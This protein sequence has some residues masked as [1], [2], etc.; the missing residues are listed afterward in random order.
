MTLIEWAKATHQNEPMKA[1]AVTAGILVIGFIVGSVIDHLLLAIASN[2]FASPIFAWITRILGIFIVFQVGKRISQLGWY[3]LPSYSDPA[4]IQQQDSGRQNM[5]TKSVSSEASNGVVYYQPV[6]TSPQGTMLVARQPGETVF[7]VKSA[8]RFWFWFL[9]LAFAVCAFTL[10]PALGGYIGYLTWDGLPNSFA[11]NPTGYIAGG[12]FWGFVAFVGLTVFAHF[13]TRPWVQV[14]V[15]PDAVNYGGQKY[16]RKHH[17]GMTLGYELTGKDNENQLKNSIFD[18][19]MGLA[20][21][22]LTYGPWGEDLPYLVNKYHSRE[23]V[24][25]MNMLIDEVVNPAT[26]FIRSRPDEEVF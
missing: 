13:R 6:R 3:Y 19:S 17:R 5:Q 21:I 1:T 4:P 9:P 7:K 14:T 2:A 18:Q 10:G 26:T 22:R 23:I 16:D 11:V 8:I 15:T 20:G 24:I 25:W 12:S